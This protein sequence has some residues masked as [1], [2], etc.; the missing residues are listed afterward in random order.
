MNLLSDWKLNR[1][2]TEFIS[3]LLVYPT[4]L[5]DLHDIWALLHHIIIFIEMRS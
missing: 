3:F 5:Q 2:N 1:G 4:R